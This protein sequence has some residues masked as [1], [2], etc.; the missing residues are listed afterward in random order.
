MSDNFTYKYASGAEVTLKSTEDAT[1]TPAVHT[2]HVNIS[3]SGLPTGAAT[4]A[5]QDTANANITSMDTA[6]QDLL[7][8]ILIALRKIELHLSI[9]SNT[10]IK[11]SDIEV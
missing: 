9:L 2:P 1:V 8:P 6:Q 3:T 11:D 5:K 10:E 4:S 7:L